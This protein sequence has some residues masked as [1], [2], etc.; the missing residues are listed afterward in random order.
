MSIDPNL[1]P[2]REAF[3]AFGARSVISPPVTVRSPHRIEIGE[4]VFVMPGAWLSVI[5]EHAGEAYEPRLCIGDRVQLGRHAVIACVGSVE[6]EADVL[7]GDRVFIGDTSHD[8]R[9]PHTP[10]ARQPMID[11]KPVRIGRGAFLGIG[12]IVL[13]GVT[14]GENGYVGAGAV[15][16]AD[17]PE[18]S[19]VV[20]NPAR[21]IRRWDEARG[22]WV[23]GG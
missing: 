14:V 18:R 7:T 15:V 9:D 20:G 22:A 3:A 10:V 1:P 17:V 5:E 4:R 11:P 23:A 2:P 6:I 8:Y 19:V 16:T 12:A 13:S 21:V